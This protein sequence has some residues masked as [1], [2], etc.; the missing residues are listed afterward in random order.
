MSAGRVAC[1]LRLKLGGYR[2]MNACWRR[3]AWF[4][5]A[6]ARHLRRRLDAIEAD[7]HGICYAYSY[8]ARR[9]FREDRLRDW[10][11]VLNQ[12]D[13]GAYEEGLM[14]EEQNRYP[15]L[16]SCVQSAPAAYWAEWREEYSLADAVV[17][18]SEFSRFCAVKSGIPSERIHVIPLAAEVSPGGR[19]ES[20]VPPSVFTP[21]R[22]LRVLYLGA[23]T[24]RKGIGR[25]FEA[26]EILAGER[27]IEFL[28]VGGSPGKLPI[29]Y[30][31]LPQT[32][33]H[34]NVA[35]EEVGRFYAAADIF[36]LPTL[37]D[38]FGRTQLEAQAWRLPI[39]ASRNCGGVVRD[40]INGMILPDVEPATIARSLR[41]CLEQP[42]ILG[43]M[44]AASRMTDEFSQSKLEERLLKLERDLGGTG[45]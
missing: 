28:I 42:R 17:V 1:D 24:L 16:A 26:I 19:D 18:N 45:P 39:I 10:I 9:F 31:N 11:R 27:C 4:Q 3:N 33:F 40:G 8:A 23:L 21:D 43:K 30:R 44:S 37:S 15:D 36:I 5:D 32:R 6:G 35:T 38:G 12:I 14:L 2:G 34:A 29:R 41:S 20:I 13:G 22:P 25:L 7:G